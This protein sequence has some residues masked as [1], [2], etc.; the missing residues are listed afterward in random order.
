MFWLCVCILTWSQCPCFSWDWRS[1]V[2][3][4]SLVVMILRLRVI[5]PSA[6]IRWLIYLVPICYLSSSGF[7]HVEIYFWWVPL[8]PPLLRPQVSLSSDYLQF[9]LGQVNERPGLDTDLTPLT[10]A[11]RP[12]SSMAVVAYNPLAQQI[13]D[14]SRDFVLT[15]LTSTIRVANRLTASTTQSTYRLHWNTID[16]WQNFDALVIAYWNAVPQNDKQHFIYTQ[17]VYSDH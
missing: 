17:S 14:L 9:L 4:P 6:L 16:V 3:C 7:S 8:P 2:G 5:H 10:S 11:S 15:Y 13:F 1:H 12:D